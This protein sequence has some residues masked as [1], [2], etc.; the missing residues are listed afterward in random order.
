MPR[1]GPRAGAGRKADP[2][3]ARQRNLRAKAARVVVEPESKA[4][5]PTEPAW[6]AGVFP[7]EQPVASPVAPAAPAEQP[8]EDDGLTD[9]QRAGITPLDYLLSIM[10]NPQASKSARMT[11]AVQAA[12]YMHAKLQP[13]GKKEEKADG[14]RKATGGRFAAAAPPRLAASGGKRLT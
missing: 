9:E 12:P 13:K 4:A 10:R 14:A 5:D 3:S 6:P 8:D 11:A 2:N 7:N 1:G